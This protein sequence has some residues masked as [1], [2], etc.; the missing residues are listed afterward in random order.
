[1]EKEKEANYKETER[2]LHPK[3]AKKKGNLLGGEV[4]IMG[5]CTWKTSAQQDMGRIV[6][7]RCRGHEREKGRSD[8]WG[9]GELGDPG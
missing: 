4:S 3:R 2:Y 5:G 6:L 1:V 8:S 7:E 9:S